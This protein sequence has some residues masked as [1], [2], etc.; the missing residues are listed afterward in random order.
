[1]RIKLAT[2]LIFFSSAIFAQPVIEGNAG[3]LTGFLKDMP[4]RVVLNYTANKSVAVNKAVVS[5]SIGTEAKRLDEALKKNSEIRSQI[6]AKLSKSGIKEGDISESKFSSTPEYGLWGDEPKSYTV[7]NTLKISIDSEKKLIQI[8]SITDNMKKVRY[9][10]TESKLENPEK[11]Q[12]DLVQQAL[13]KIGFKQKLYEK[14]L[15]LKLKP[16]KFS[17]NVYQAEE[18]RPVRERQSSLSKRLVSYESAPMKFGETR[19]IA[20]V[21]VV[22][23]VAKD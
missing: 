15:G 21:E 11:F 17:E 2:F 6:K 18:I 22:F 5:I 13:D 9:I 16:V 3:D 4:N 20:D 10:S 8:A 1:M 19:L 14:S 12:N 23:E 7:E